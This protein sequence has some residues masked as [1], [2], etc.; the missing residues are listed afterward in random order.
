[1]KQKT[2]LVGV[3]V[4]YKKVKGKPAWFLVKPKEDSD[5]ELPKTNARRGESSVRSAIRMM[6]EQAAM[7]V[8]VLE[9][10]GRAAGTAV[11]G[12][13]PLPQKT[14]YYLILFKE[15]NEVL[16]FV[17]YLWLDYTKAVRKFKNKKDLAMLKIARDL[18]KSL[19]KTRGKIS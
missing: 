19:E 9:E 5:W 14:I 11:V 13:K 4:V 15:A 6:G 2:I 18:L 16:G 10:V 12:G 17:D 3:A 1:M 7:N 8:K